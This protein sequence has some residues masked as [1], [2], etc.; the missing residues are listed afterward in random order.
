MKLKI[1]FMIIYKNL[2]I[3]RDKCD[4]RFAKPAHRKLGNV[5]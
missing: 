4:K 1:E 2:K 5:V 3:L